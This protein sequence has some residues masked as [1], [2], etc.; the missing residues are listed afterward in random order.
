MFWLRFGVQHF[1]YTLTHAQY[2]YKHLSMINHKQT[3]TNPTQI[4]LISLI[5][6]FFFFFFFYFIKVAYIV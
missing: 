6:F 3:L 1:T 4:L 5:F 2:S